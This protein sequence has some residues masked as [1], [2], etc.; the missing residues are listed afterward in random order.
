MAV[1]VRVW[2]LWVVPAAHKSVPPEA[3]AVGGAR[4]QLGQFWGV[5]RC[6]SLCP[7]HGPHPAPPGVGPSDEVGPLGSGLE[8]ISLGVCKASGPAP[9]ES[10]RCWLPVQLGSVGLAE[11]SAACQTTVTCSLR[12]CLLGP[13]SVP[14]SGV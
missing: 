7:A 14:G 5:R 11:R 13:L 8:L 1:S 10:G 3:R 4:Q 6:L 9:L 2:G 12:T